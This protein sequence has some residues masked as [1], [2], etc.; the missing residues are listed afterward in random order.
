MQNIICTFY[1]YFV[2]LI[3]R[4]FIALQKQAMHT[5]LTLTIEMNFQ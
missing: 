4:I 1:S 2:Y 3:L 5:E